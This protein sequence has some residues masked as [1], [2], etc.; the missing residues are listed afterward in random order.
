MNNEVKTLSAIAD[1]LETT[2]F[3]IAVKIGILEVLKHSLIQA[4]ILSGDR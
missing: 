1:L 3:S 4:A 2:D